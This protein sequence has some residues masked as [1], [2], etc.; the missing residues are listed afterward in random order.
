M[1][2]YAYTYS[3]DDYGFELFE[4]EKV[5]TRVFYTV[6]ATRTNDDS[7]TDT[8]TFQRCVNFSKDS[9]NWIVPR[10]IDSTTDLTPVARTDFVSLDSLS[11]PAD[12]VTWVTAYYD[13]EPK[14]KELLG[15]EVDRIIDE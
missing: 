11:I 12:L 14:R 4:G 7:T 1:A 6:N 8:C 9:K 3:I 2:T 13:N 10:T 15:T 5:I